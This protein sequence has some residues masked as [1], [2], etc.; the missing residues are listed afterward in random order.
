MR[1]KAR[2]RDL[3]GYLFARAKAGIEH[4][5][6]SKPI[7]CCPVIGEMF[8]LPTHGP[9]PAKPEPGEILVNRSLEFR[10][11]TRGID[12]FNAQDETP[13]FSP[14]GLIGGEGRQRMAEMQQPG[15]TWR[16]TGDNHRPSTY[17]DG[18]QTAGPPRHMPKRLR[19]R[20]DLTRAVSAVAALDPRLAAIAR[21]VGELPLRLREPGFKSLIAII[22]DQ[23]ISRSAADAIFRR[24]EAALDLFTAEAW[25]KMGDQH[26]AGVGLSRPKLK[27]ARAV[28]ER[29]ADGRLDLVRLSRLSD[30]NARAHLIETPG[31]GR[32]TADIYLLSCLGRTDVWPA[33]DLA[34]QVAATAA[35]GKRKRLNERQ[36]D[37]IAEI[38]RP[39][40]GVAARLLWAHYRM[41]RTKEAA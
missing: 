30:E 21:D 9:L 12:I 26:L 38:W 25:L 34:L 40:R 28:A 17:T 37:A 22:V 3:I 14:R 6:R 13:A 16:E 15:W 5:H 2:T 27:H 23:Q 11:R 41:L 31:I 10:S 4:A 18:R 24:L 1:R 36:M 39:W 19:N 32:W 7:E 8:R 33:G 35:L 29:V 20:T